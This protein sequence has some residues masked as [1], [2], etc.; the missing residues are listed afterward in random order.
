MKRLIFFLPLLLFLVCTM[1]AQQLGPAINEEPLEE[2]FWESMQ[3]QGT[4]LDSLV[5]WQEQVLLHMDREAI[6]PKD[7]L[8]FKAYV[9]TGT[10]QLRV[11]ASHVL[12]VELLDENGTLVN[13]Q[14]HKISNGSAEGSMMIPKKAKSGK[15]FLRAYTR[16]MLNY[17]PENFAIKELSITDKKNTL[18]ILNGT[19]TDIKI[20]PEGGTMI[21]GL[22]NRIAI[23]TEDFVGNT[24]TVI[25]GNGNKITEVQSYG[26]GLGTFLLTPKYGST[27][28]LELSNGKR[29]ALPVAGEVGYTMQ[30]NNIIGDKVVIKIEATKDVKNQEAF[31]RGRINGFNFFESKITFKNTNSTEIEIPKEDLPNGIVLLQLEDEFDQVWATRPVHIDNNQLNFEIE[32]SSNP[33]NNLLKIKVTD[34]KGAPI[35]T[36]LSVALSEERENSNL[37]PSFDQPRNQRFLNDLLVLTNRLPNDYALNKVTELPTEIKYNFQEGL[38]FYGRAYDLDAVPLPTTL[39]QVVISGGG[40]ALA[41]EVM[42]NDEGLFKL[43]G[44]QVN[45]EADMIFRRAAEDQRD[46]FV[47]VVPYQYETP[48][49][50]IKSTKDNKGL[51]SKQFIPKK[52]VAEF[53][54]VENMD[55]L[56]TLEG[57]SLI[58][59]KY[60]SSR[61]PS[62]YNIQPDR[63]A[64][65]DP[66]KPKFIS[67]LFLNIP[68][69]S[70]TG[71]RDYPVLS[72]LNREGRISGPSG[73]SLL[74]QPGP[75]WI[76]DGFPVGNSTFFD[77]EWGLTHNDIDRIELLLRAGDTSLWGSRA[78]Q[79]VILIYTRN[80]SDVQYLNRKKAQLTFE[81]YHDSLSFDSYKKQFMGKKSKTENT[82]IYWNPSLATDGN[83]EAVIALPKEMEEGDK[84]QLDV[85]AITEDGKNGSLKTTL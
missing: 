77:P 26:N 59:E 27:Y 84:I 28:S 65:Q 13:S 23:S 32:K 39:I 69:V 75:L 20:F 19:P 47:K 67:E 10:E 40:K 81:G 29:V 51:N 4:A 53:K 54:E 82:T 55:R 50:K 43:S 31:L 11:S 45:G 24:F 52:Q 41:H 38:E 78:S 57:V 66:E 17:G 21:T 15:H 33:Q 72:I 18:P 49:L 22:E 73:P 42:T 83:G 8:F 30:I 25:D 71:S 64:Y 34:A 76:I 61:S 46:K 1:N 79:G 60:K 62:V 7:H 80:G 44:L 70:V 12:K 2:V 56:I 6:A 14:Y 36:E 68:G 3:T 37:Y 16:W 63:V 74:D 9:L 5:V 35:K 48:P 58:G 85:K